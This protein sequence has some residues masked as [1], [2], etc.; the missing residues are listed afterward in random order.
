MFF[1]YSSLNSSIVRSPLGTAPLHLLWPQDQASTDLCCLSSIT[2]VVVEEEGPEVI[3][4]EEEEEEVRT[5]VAAE[6]AATL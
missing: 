6:A 4:E 3:T 2:A 5:A 1:I